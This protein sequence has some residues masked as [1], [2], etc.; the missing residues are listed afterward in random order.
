MK[1][2]TKLAEIIA[3][4]RDPVSG[5]PWD[6]V[7]THETLKKYL[8]EESYEVIDAIDSHKGLKEEL[9][10]VLLQVM[11]HSQIASDNK[12][13]T[14]TDVVSDLSN[15]LVERHPHVFGNTTAS[16][17]SEAVNSWNNAKAQ[18]DAESKK[19]TL[20]GVPRSMPALQRAQK[21]SD[22]AVAVGFDWPDISGVRDQVLEEVKEFV[23]A[24]AEK[25]SDKNIQL[26][27]GD[28]L[29]SLVQIARKSGF[30]AEEAL[31]ATV[32]KFEKRFNAME[33]EIKKPLKECS[34]EEMNQTW[35]KVKQYEKN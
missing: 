5:C 9:G 24:C 8:I 33:D 17:V 34:V 23:D 21:I 1:E 20:A 4:L 15:K 18:K 11:L 32:N 14:I 29:F 19:R 12:D 28:V 16:N 35:Q 27:F 26:E 25:Q 6:K 13:F 2:F 3:K 7:Q 22:K 10:D 30:S 31:S